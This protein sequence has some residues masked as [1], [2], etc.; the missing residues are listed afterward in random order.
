LA[1]KDARSPALRP[2]VLERRLRLQHEGSLTSNELNLWLARG[3]RVPLDSAERPVRGSFG[4]WK[5]GGFG[6]RG[7]CGSGRLSDLSVTKASAASSGISWGGAR[8]SLG[9]GAGSKRTGA[10]GGAT[11]CGSAGSEEAS[12]GAGTDSGGVGSTGAGSPGGGST[13]TGS[14]GAAP[15]ASGG[16]SSCGGERFRRQPARTR[17]RTW[18]S[19]GSQTRNS[20]I[21]ENHSPTTHLVVCKRF[22]DSFANSIFQVRRACQQGPV[23]SWMD[24]GCGDCYDHY[25]DGT[26]CL[27]S[28]IA[29]SAGS[30]PAI[31]TPSQVQPGRH[32]LLGGAH[33]ERPFAVEELKQ[34]ERTLCLL[35]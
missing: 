24:I 13:G 31:P 19:P 6:R 30:A 14:T 29:S 35:I 3:G 2:A 7:R 34:S 18:R 21:F 28:M 12:A 15:V 16:G 22:P 26:D 32:R 33:K 11:D 27:G 23:L 1:E 8:S 25:L 5:F 9:A 10:A 4:R 20:D 17:C